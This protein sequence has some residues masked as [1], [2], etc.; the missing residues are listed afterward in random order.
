[1]MVFDNQNINQSVMTIDNVN[2]DELPMRQEQVQLLFPNDDDN[3]ILECINDINE[4]I[5][6]SSIKNDST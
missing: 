5:N 1:M 6:P 3:M 2:L 4:N